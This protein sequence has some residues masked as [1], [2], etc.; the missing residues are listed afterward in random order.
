MLVADLLASIGH[1]EARIFVLS[2]VRGVSLA[3]I[4]GDLGLNRN[5]AASRL[6]ATRR[7][8]AGLLDA[9]EGRHVRTCPPSAG[10]SVE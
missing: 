7:R 4:A 3:R 6:R 5:T 1:T 10:V 9:D 8:L 2:R